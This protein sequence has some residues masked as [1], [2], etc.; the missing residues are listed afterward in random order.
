MNAFNYHNGQLQ[1]EDLPLAEIARRHGTPAYVYS[2]AA[3]ESNFRAY[4][5]ALQGQEHLVCYAVKANSNLAVLNT[6]ARLGAG[7]DIV[8]GGELQRV[9]AA[10]GDP[11]KVVYSGVAKSREEMGA[12]L[13]A[14]I[15]CFNIES[16]AE[17]E[18]L[19]QVAADLDR[20]AAIC[21]PAS[22]SRAVLR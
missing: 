18:R 7:F 3:L 10:G 5:D 19:Q 12:A 4:Q 8:S 15:L 17:L 16:A 6:L 11:A 13:E 20:T 21:A 1:A 2:R 22:N 14:G 9:I